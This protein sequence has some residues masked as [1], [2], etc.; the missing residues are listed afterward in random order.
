MHEWNCPAVSPPC[1]IAAD[2][3]WT[4]RAAGG[5]YGAA[6]SVYRLCTLCSNKQHMLLL[7]SS[8][9]SVL[10][11]AVGGVCCLT[12]SWVAITGVLIALPAR[13]TLPQVPLALQALRA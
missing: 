3:R 10:R 1:A 11:I 7:T 5:I 9:A 12:V 8:S 13:S 6:L 2:A 4:V